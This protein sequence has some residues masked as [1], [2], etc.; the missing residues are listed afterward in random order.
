MANTNQKLRMLLEAERAQNKALRE[1]LEK[2]AN[3]YA[4]LQRNRK[5]YGY[6]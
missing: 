6:Y 4:L 1:Q 2:H 5:V 3:E